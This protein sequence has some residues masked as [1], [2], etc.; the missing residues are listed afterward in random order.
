MTIEVIHTGRR[1]YIYLQ[2]DAGKTSEIAIVDDFYG[3]SAVTVHL[4]AGG[5][6]KL[7]VSVANPDLTSDSP[8][9]DNSWVDWSQG[10][11][12]ETTGIE[13]TPSLTQLVL[14]PSY[15]F[16]RNFG[17]SGKGSLPAKAKIVN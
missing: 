14:R 4:G 10:E 15:P 12:S 7:Q 5:T 9:P 13:V 6:A 3:A 17:R 8:I 1:Q 11:I 2:A 16:R